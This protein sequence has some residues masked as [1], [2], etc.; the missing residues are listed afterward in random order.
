LLLFF[1]LKDFILKEK[2]QSSPYFSK[3]STLLK[4]YL[5]RMSRKHNCH[6]VSKLKFKTLEKIR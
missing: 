5:N 2:L 4:V 1:V 6:W 3:R